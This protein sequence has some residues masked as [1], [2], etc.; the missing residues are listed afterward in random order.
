[1]NSN[2]FGQHFKISTFGESHGNAMG[3]VIDGCPAGL[4][5]DFDLLKLDLQRRKPGKSNLPA[6]QVVSPRNE[7]DDFEILSGVLNGKTLG[8]PIALVIRNQ[9]AKSHDYQNIGFRKG[10][11]DDVWQKK[12]GIADLRGG[13]RASA[14]ETVA[15]V[16]AGSIA[17]MLLKKW[18]PKLNFFGFS[19]SI[20]AFNLSVEELAVLKNQKK[21]NSEFIDQCPARFLGSNANE[22]IS[23]LQQLQQDNDSIGGAVQMVIEN[24]P[25][26]L[27]QPVFNKLK[28]DLSAAMLSVGG[29]CGFE[30]GMNTIDNLKL[31]GKEFHSKNFYGGIRGGISTGEEIYF[32]IY[33]KPTSSIMDVA[34]NGRHD[35]C[36]LPRAIPVFEAM[37]ALVL[38]DHVLAMRLDRV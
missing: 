30:L 4:D 23:Y 27:G 38:A 13:G 36:L 10:H 17:K 26:N 22:V 35:P 31:T 24:A 15:R 16:A 19:Q 25:E 9:D 12:F 6:N 20:G 5:F 14:R 21:I 28:S 32:R 7:P 29:T 2:S 1:M 11:A 33:M 8:T 18:Y 34:K 3:A 37:T